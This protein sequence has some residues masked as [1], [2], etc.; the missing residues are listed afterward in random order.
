MSSLSCF[1]KACLSAHTGRTG[2]NQQDS[3]EDGLHGGDTPLVMNQM[4]I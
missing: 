3:R 1:I 4:E 2:K